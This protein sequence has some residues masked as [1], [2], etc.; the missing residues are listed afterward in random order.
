MINKSI[1][2]LLKDGKSPNLAA[3]M[4]K[5]YVLLKKSYYA[6]AL[7]ILEQQPCKTCICMDCGK[8]MKVTEQSGHLKECPNCPPELASTEFAKEI[9]EETSKKKP[10][11]SPST[12]WEHLH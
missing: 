2:K 4:Q 5:R 7:A 6:Q 11:S 3:H 10:E 8:V 12:M 1:V 9:T